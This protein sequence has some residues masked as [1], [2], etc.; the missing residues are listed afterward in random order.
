MTALACLA[1][2]A[3]FAQAAPEDETVLRCAQEGTCLVVDAPTALSGAC[4]AGDEE[5][6]FDVYAHAHAVAAQSLTELQ[7]PDWCG[8]LV[9]QR[10][11]TLVAVYGNEACLD[12]WHPGWRKGQPLDAPRPANRTELMNN[13]VLLDC[14]GKLM[15]DASRHAAEPPWVV[16]HALAHATVL[17]S[18]G[19]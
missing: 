18:I 13:P 1:L 12:A 9:D 17:A 8:R 19:G 16:L 6:R 5:V 11:A 14:L 3:V 4:R 7:W 10:G 2:A 15:D